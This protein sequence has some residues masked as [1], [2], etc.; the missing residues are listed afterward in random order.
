MVQNILRREDVERVTGL[1]RS[2][3]YA[4]IAAGE[5]PKP[6]KLGIRAS[7]WLEEDVAGWQ[8]AR[9]AASRGVAA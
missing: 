4:K 8:R 2:S 6:I 3:L 7:G 5:F 1:P 9:I